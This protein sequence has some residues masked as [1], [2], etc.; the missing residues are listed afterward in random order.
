MN[1]LI[2]TGNHYTTFSMSTWRDQG[3]TGAINSTLELAQLLVKKGHQVTVSG[4]VTDEESDGITFTATSSLE[5]GTHYDAVIA[6]SYIHYLKELDQREVTFD[7]SML[8]IHQYAPYGWWRGELL[9][10]AGANEFRDPRMTWVV[11]LSDIQAR[12]MCRKYP[13]ATR[14]VKLIGSAVDADIFKSTKK[15]PNSFI[16]CQPPHKGLDTLLSIWPNVREL[17]PDATLTVALP[18]TGNAEEQIFNEEIDGV[19]YAGSLSRPAL[20]NEIATSEYWLNPGDH[21]EEFGLTALEMMAGGVKIVSTDKGF[22]KH[23][24]ADKAS[25]I[26]TSD[27]DI[28]S[29]SITA[30][31]YYLDNPDIAQEHRER[32]AEFVRGENWDSRYESWLELLTSE[33]AAFIKHKALYTYFD[34]PAAWKERFLSYGAR[35]KE[36]ELIVDEP[37][38]NCFSFQL[39]SEE[40]CQLIRD[41]AEHSQAWT[42]DRHQNYPTTDMLLQVLDLEDTYRQILEEYVVPMASTMWEL[43]TAWAKFRAETFLAKY[44]PKAQG[45]LSIHHD[46]SDITCLIQLSDLHEYEGGGTFF[47]RQ[48]K[49]IKNGIGYA[50]VHPGNIT[51]MHGGRAISKGLRY[52]LVSFIHRNR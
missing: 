22:H 10:Q 43:G 50:T 12:N 5:A 35:T 49:L 40:F 37:F 27:G 33:P 13:Y 31:R 14:K 47:K 46:E 15:K 48:K 7:K 32:C 4:D 6:V 20:A 9:D 26:D 2:Y 23:L 36:W 39:F 21:I 3:A 34:D 29:A 17:L 51:H 41:E 45:H 44:T 8:W 52:I 38:D 16:T 28:E 18:Y 42:T 25:I 1:I 19:T 11:M 24:L 30:L